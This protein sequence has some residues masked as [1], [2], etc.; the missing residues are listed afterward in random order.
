MEHQDARQAFITYHKELNGRRNTLTEILQMKLFPWLIICGAI[1]W[2]AVRFIG[3]Q[4]L[5]YSVFAS[6]ICLLLVLAIEIHRN[7][8]R[9]IA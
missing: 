6:V 1:S 4:T 7:K 9:P 3:I 5:Y 8:K 2:L